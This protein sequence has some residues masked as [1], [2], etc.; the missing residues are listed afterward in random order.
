[1]IWV[2]ALVARPYTWWRLCLVAAM[3]AGMVLAFAVPFLR[4]FFALRSYVAASDVIAVVIAAGAGI[5]LTVFLAATGRLP[6]QRDRGGAR[7]AGDPAGV[8]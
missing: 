8:P 3:T 6:G 2:L 5:V 4:T 1:A 7:Q